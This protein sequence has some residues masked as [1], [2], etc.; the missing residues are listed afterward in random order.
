MSTHIFT[1]E[2]VGKLSRNPW[3]LKCSERS[4]TYTYDFKRQALEQHSQGISP[5]D[6]WRRA[7]FDISRWKKDYARDILKGWKRIVK[8]RGFKGLAGSKGRPRGLPKTKAATDAD[9][10]KHLELEVAYLKAENDFL[11]RL[12]AK[13]AESN[14]GQRK[15]MK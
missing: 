5:R 4:I 14:S 2:E 1:S 11:E 15:N 13:R 12:R 8:K 6:V 10:I 9:K 3:V 7:G